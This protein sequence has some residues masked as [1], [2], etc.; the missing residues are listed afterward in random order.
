[1]TNLLVL[2]VAADLVLL[3]HHLGLEHLLLRIA[4]HL[5]EVLSLV[6]V[7]SFEIVTFV[8]LIRFF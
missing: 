2:V 5:L 8:E 6:L 1:M 3:I 7:S 4:E